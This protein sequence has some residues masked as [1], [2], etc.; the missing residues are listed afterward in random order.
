MNALNFYYVNVSFIFLFIYR[1]ILPDRRNRSQ[2]NFSRT[3][4]SVWITKLD[5]SLKYVGC[6]GEGK[7]VKKSI[8]DRPCLHKLWHRGEVG[9]R[10]KTRE[11]SWRVSITSVSG[12]NNSCTKISPVR[13]DVAWHVYFTFALAMPAISTLLLTCSL[14]FSISWWRI[15]SYMHIDFIGCIKIVNHNAILLY[16]LFNYNARIR[17][18]YCTYYSLFVIFDHVGYVQVFDTRLCQITHTNLRLI[19]RSAERAKN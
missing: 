2:A 8:F 6:R 18:I 3:C 11:L 13:G 5:T 9:A 16:K 19:R 7:N 12:G 14:C 4:P 17:H 10:I 15:K 1:T